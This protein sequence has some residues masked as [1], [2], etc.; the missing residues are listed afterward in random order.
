CLLMGGLRHREQVFRVEG[1]GAGLAALISLAT[2]SLVL[3][4]FTTSSEAGTYTVAQ[5]G[6]VAVASL[7]LWGVFVFVQTVRHRDYFLPLGDAAN[8]DVHA[9]PPSVATAWTSFGLLMV[10]L[11]SVIGL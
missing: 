8:I 9:P 3:P 5:L 4:T 7:L 11:V 6:F 2:L 1:T 10:T